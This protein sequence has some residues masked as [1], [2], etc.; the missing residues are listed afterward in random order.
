MAFA[1][2]ILYANDVTLTTVAI[3]DKQLTIEI[4]ILVVIGDFK[5]NVS[6]NIPH[7]NIPA[8]FLWIFFLVNKYSYP[9]IELV[10]PHGLI[11]TNMGVLWV[12]KLLSIP[13]WS[14]M[15]LISFTFT[16]EFNCVNWL[17]SFMQMGCPFLY[18]LESYWG[19][20]IL[21]RFKQYLG[22][23]LISLANATFPLN[24]DAAPIE[25]AIESVSE[26]KCPINM[27]PSNKFFFQIRLL[28]AI[29][30]HSGDWIWF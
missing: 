10:L 14:I 13:W 20:A 1:W 19:I 9:I 22:S 21:K 24:N 30:S 26:F 28:S 16:V 6:D 2:N 12:I 29:I 11:S 4:S 27:Q 25:D 15:L 23:F 18:T 7:N 17:W 3:F 8:I 5:F